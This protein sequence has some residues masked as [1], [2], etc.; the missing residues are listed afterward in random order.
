MATGAVFGGDDT[1]P[2]YAAF[3]H[4]VDRHNG[5]VS[6][7]MRVDKVTRFVDVTNNAIVTR[8]RKS[9]GSLSTK[10]FHLLYVMGGA[11]GVA[12]GGRAPPPVPYA[13]STLPVHC[14]CIKFM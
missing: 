4:E 11:S 3:R 1:V 13:L 10:R 9:S 5:N 8:T 14:R 12:E 7:T 2:A 6:A